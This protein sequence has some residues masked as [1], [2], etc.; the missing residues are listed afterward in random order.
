[1]SND[2]A[3]DVGIDA[4]NNDI[5]LSFPIVPQRK[6]ATF[7]SPKYTYVFKVGRYVF[8]G[9][10]RKTKSRKSQQNFTVEYNR[11]RLMLAAT[12]SVLTRGGGR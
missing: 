7:D 3:V 1:M 12:S 5:L 11:L 10:E 8:Q 6:K 4:N 2:D 9:K